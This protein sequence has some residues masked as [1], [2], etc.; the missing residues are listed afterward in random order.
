MADLPNVDGAVEGYF[1]AGVAL[2]L[3]WPG[4]SDGKLK[5]FGATMAETRPGKND[6]ELTYADA[7]LIIPEVAG[8]YRWMMAANLCQQC[9]MSESPKTSTKKCNINKG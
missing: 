2:G 1:L 9:Q 5:G 8:C 7:V 3:C 4:E 6:L